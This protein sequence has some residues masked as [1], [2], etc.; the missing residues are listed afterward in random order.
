MSDAIKNGSTK[1]ELPDPKSA[2]NNHICNHQ[3]SVEMWQRAFPEAKI[4]VKPFA[5]DSFFEECIIKDIFDYIG[6]T[7]FVDFNFPKRQNESLCLPG[8]YVLSRLN[9]RIPKIVSG[10]ISPVRGDLANHIV[11]FFH[12]KSKYF[13][14]KKE[15]QA[16]EGEF[17]DSQRWIAEKFWN[18]NFELWGSPRKGIS[19]KHQESVDCISRLST[20][21]YMSEMIE[22]FA[23]AWQKNKLK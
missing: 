11:Q 1:L 23:S 21:I 18:G 6:V 14:S 2:Y 19:R 20:D 12:V 15:V 5:R 4:V 7:D 8:M 17:Y 13:P 16:Y 10:R 9:Q 3:L 22:C